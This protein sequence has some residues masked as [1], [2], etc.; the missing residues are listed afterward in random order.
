MSFYYVLKWLQFELEKS[1]EGVKS[2]NL[3]ANV[4]INK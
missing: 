1:K 3:L 4:I 2:E